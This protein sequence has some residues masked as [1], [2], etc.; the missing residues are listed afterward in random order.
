MLTAAFIVLFVA[1]GP[2]YQLLT[3]PPDKQPKLPDFM[4]W[5][6]P[7]LLALGT[8]AFGVFLLTRGLAAHHWIS[9]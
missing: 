1:V 9:N 7:F 4:P 3:L 8:T 6:L 5:P 2:I